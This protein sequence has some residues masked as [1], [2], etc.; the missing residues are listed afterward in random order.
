MPV[1]RHIARGNIHQATEH[2]G[3]LYIGGITPD[4]ASLDMYGQAR[5]LFAKLAGI[6]D[7]LGSSPDHVLLVTCFLCDMSKKA[8]MNRA[9]REVFPPEIAPARVCPGIVAIEEGV[10]LEISVIAAKADQ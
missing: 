6:L 3:V 7:E 9:W 5:Q 8:E 2:K 1:S 4:D 10:L